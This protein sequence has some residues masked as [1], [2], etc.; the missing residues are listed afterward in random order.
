[1]YFNKCINKCVIIAIYTI[2]LYIILYYIADI[3]VQIVFRIEFC[4]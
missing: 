4:V 1:M 3:N 2:Y